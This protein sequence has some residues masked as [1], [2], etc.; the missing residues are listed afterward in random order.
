MTLIFTIS[1]AHEPPKK[2]L[3]VISSLVPRL[4]HIGLAMAGH[5]IALRM[6]SCA[7]ALS[8]DLSLE[9]AIYGIPV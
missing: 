5:D 7:V 2:G 6:T 3:L 4:G 1:G 8:I 9:I